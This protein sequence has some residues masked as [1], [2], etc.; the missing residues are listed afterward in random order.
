MKVQI[1]NIGDVKVLSIH[2]RVDAVTAQQLQDK[3]LETAHHSPKLLIDLSSVSYM[4]SAGLRVILL[5]HR[6]MRE[7]NGRVVL[8]GLQDRIRDAMEITGFLK[9]FSV[10]TDIQAGIEMIG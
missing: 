2:G 6:E 7:H 4:S 10:V 1:M 9:H 3:A 8:V 5:L